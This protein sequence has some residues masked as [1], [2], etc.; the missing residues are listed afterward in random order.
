MHDS[1]LIKG[2]QQVKTQL[3]ALFDETVDAALSSLAIALDPEIILELKERI[4]ALI[5]SE[6]VNDI[7]V[8]Q[9]L[10]L[11]EDGCD[12]ITHLYMSPKIQE[13]LGYT[14]EELARIGFGSI[15]GKEIMSFYRDRDHVEEKITPVPEA[16][17]R[18][19]AGFL[20]NSNWEGI[21]KLRKKNGTDIWVVDKAVITQFRNTLKDNVVC[22][23]AGLLL[24]TTDLLAGR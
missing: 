22:I 5:F 19:T 13:I 2:I 4:A 18:R 1:T 16:Q 3:T 7:P 14:A 15:V 20:G 23:S 6:H 9:Y 17:A 11:W 10:A 24:E 12:E 21:Y 8:T